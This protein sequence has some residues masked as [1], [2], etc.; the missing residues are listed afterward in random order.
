MIGLGVNF[1][2]E[3]DVEYIVLFYEKKIRGVKLFEVSVGEYLL[4]LK[5]WKEYVEKKWWIVKC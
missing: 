1:I 5:Y 4:V 3:V 2:V